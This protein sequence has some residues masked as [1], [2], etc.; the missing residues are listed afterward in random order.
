MIYLS[1][2][3]NLLLSVRHCFLPQCLCTWGSPA[4]TALR[5]HLQLGL[6]PRLPRPES[7]LLT[8]LCHSRRISSRGSAGTQHSLM[9]G[10]AIFRQNAFS[11]LRCQGTSLFPPFYR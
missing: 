1:D 9:K 2:P 8:T 5:L 11:F 10:T 3:R 4:W 7:M 6:E